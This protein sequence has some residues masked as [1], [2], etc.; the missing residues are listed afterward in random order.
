[1]SAQEKDESWRGKIGK[2]STDEIDGFL[3]EPFLARVACLDD[4]DWPY[5]VPCWYQWDGAALWVVPRAR[6]AWAR[7]L[8]ARPRCAVTIDES[9]AADRASDTG[10]HRAS[11][12]YRRA[13]TLGAHDEL[14][15][16]ADPPRPRATWQG[17]GWP[18]RYLEGNAVGAAECRP[19]AM[20]YSLELNIFRSRSG[21]CRVR[22]YGE[23][24]NSLLKNRATW[25]PPLYEDRWK[26]WLIRLRR[27]SSNRAV[28]RTGTINDLFG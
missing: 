7:H 9:S 5:V 18:A 17:I 10:V 11:R 8:E 13:A 27:T 15:A 16:L 3:N 12:R 28:E 19:M 26:R 21:P 25:S 2:M 14:E 4:N 1:M 22:Y 20:R 24:G 6:S 23:N